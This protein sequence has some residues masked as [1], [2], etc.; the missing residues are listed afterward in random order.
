MSNCLSI[1]GPL[2]RLTPRSGLR[3]RGWPF[4]GAQPGLAVFVLALII[5]Q[6]LVGLGQGIAAGAE[7]VSAVA[8]RVDA[9]IRRSWQANGVQ[10][11]SPADDAAFLRR[12]SLHVGGSIP[13]VSVVR[14]F[15]ADPA[16]DKRRQYVESL[17]DG[18]EYLAHFARFWQRTMLPDSQNAFNQS[19][20]G[21]AFE[22]WLQQRLLAELPYDEMVRQILAPASIQEDN[23]NVAFSRFSQNATPSPVA[24]SVLRESSPENLA[25]GATRVFLGIRLECAQCHDH[26]FDTWKQ[27][28]FWSMAAFFGP[29]TLGSNSSGP[30]WSIKVPGT[31]RVALAAYLDGSKP[32]VTPG[33][34]GR[35]TL[36][37]W[38]T[39]RDNSQFAAATVNRLWG[40]FF[41]V[42]LVDPV[43]DFSEHNPPSHPE[44][45]ALLAEEFIRHDYDLKFVIR[46]IIATEAYQLSS[47]RTD[48]S[49]DEVRL[50]GRMRAQGMSAFQVVSSYQQAVGWQSIASDQYYYPGGRFVSDGNLAEFVQTLSTDSGSPLE[51]ETSILQSLFLMNSAFVS[52]TTRSFHQG[53]SSIGAI[54]SS[55]FMSQ[56]DR[57]DTVYLT[58]L[59]RLP[60]SAEREQVRRIF[61]EPPAA[62][63][64]ATEPR[65]DGSN[66]PKAAPLVTGLIRM[67]N[68][69]QPPPRVVPR[70]ISAEEAGLSDLFWALL[71]SSEFHLNH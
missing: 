35:A 10:P 2:P 50:Y 17:L 18:P 40:H 71:N 32:V 31:A 38:I 46:V 65:A 70:Q 15:L 14:E 43:D 12:V 44:L 13:P 57:I 47:L 59:T 64:S 69:Q 62:D 24:F 26:P 68:Q 28:Q 33:A 36:A 54:V 21:G 45:L 60:T 27:D 8:A 20:Q 4:S 37:R 16:P 1:R 9:E 11:T 51:Q 34:E 5:G 19:Q 25:S 61:L 23:R 6:G 3:H 55:P 42:G 29:Q 67:I 7:D 41:G 48:P 63:P 56:D 52:L 39:S 53:R 30:Q 22:V 66:P 49:Q 58:T